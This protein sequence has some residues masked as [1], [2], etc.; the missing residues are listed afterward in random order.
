MFIVSEENRLFKFSTNTETDRQRWI[1]AL[2]VARTTALEIKKG[3]G[4][5]KKNI[6]MIV[7]IYDS[8]DTNIKKR[9]NLRKK[10]DAHLINI[11]IEH[12]GSEIM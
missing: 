6:D 1:Q 12:Y 7:K 2:D 5:I 3:G 10:I 8:G 11:L 4:Q 9:E